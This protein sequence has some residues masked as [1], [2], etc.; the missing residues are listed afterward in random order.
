MATSIDADRAAIEAGLREMFSGHQGPVA[1]AMRYATLG[2][3][4]R[5][6]PLL[7][8]RV[9]RMLAADPRLVLPGGLAVEL[10]HAAS[11]VVDDLPCM[12]DAETRRGQPAA[13]RAHGEATAILAAFG[14]VAMAGRVALPREGSSLG[15]EAASFQQALLGT[16]DCST[17][18]G[19]QA[20]DLGLDLALGDRQSLRVKAMKTAPLFELAAHAGTLGSRAG[21]NRRA[22]VRRLGREFGLAFQLVDDW[23]D[24]EL[25]TDALPRQQL[26]IV[27]RMLSDYGN[28]A[29]EVMEILD[30]LDARLNNHVPAAAGDQYEKSLA[31]RAA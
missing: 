15:E 27:R 7:A 17:L 1:A 2:K 29:N 20:A 24:H 14:M 22:E 16:L 9:G 8:L 25:D 18:L 28:R 19:G 4:Q 5:I 3:G 23:L 26:E 12:D 11:L 21:R 13:H 30:Y 10:L 6:R 31:S